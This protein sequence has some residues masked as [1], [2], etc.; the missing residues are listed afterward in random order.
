MQDLKKLWNTILGELEVEV[1]E[2]NFLTL[3][4]RTSL[5]S[6]E[7]SVA[8]IAVPSA[9][10]IDLLQRKFYPIIKKSIDKHAGGDNQI[11]FVP[12]TVIDV[13]EAAPKDGTLFYG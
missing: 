12:K 7:N 4:K 8:T 13:L 2:A 1:S 6:L 3:F 10:I 11:M 9:M 5:I